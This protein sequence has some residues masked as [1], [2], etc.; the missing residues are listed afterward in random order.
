MSPAFVK[1]LREPCLG[2]VDARVVR[3]AGVRTTQQEQK[4]FQRYPETGSTGLDH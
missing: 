1:E 3:R 2:L 4:E